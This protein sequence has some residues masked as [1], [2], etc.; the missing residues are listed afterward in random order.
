MKALKKM[1]AKLNKRLK[2]FERI[3]SDHEGAFTRPGSLK[4]KSR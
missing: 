4:K 1:Q 3:K 2:D